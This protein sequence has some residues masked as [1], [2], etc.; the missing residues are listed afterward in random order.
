MKL[1]TQQTRK[2]GNVFWRDGVSDSNRQRIVDNII[3]TIA[4]RHSLALDEEMEAAH[5]VARYGF[6][7]VDTVTYAI[8]ESEETF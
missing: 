2:D 5:Q 1:Y 4:R 3:E 7:H 6:V 8:R